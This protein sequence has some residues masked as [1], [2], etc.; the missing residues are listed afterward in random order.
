M[1]VDPHLF[2]HRHA[3]KIS[4]GS[5]RIRCNRLWLKL[6]QVIRSENIFRS[7]E[8][9]NKPEWRRRPD[10][11]PLKA[12]GTRLAMVLAPLVS[13]S[14]VCKLQICCWAVIVRAANCIDMQLCWGLKIGSLPQAMADVDAPVPS[15][16]NEEFVTKAWIERAA[17]IC[18]G[19]TNGS[20]AA[21]TSWVSESAMWVAES[22]WEQSRVINRRRPLEG[23]FV[24]LSSHKNPC[25]FHVNK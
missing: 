19:T 7:L 12:I 24:E 4:Q 1:R 13:W 15:S 10:M 20:W 18:V 8:K 22:S 5:S 23:Q 16:C 11:K 25:T 17:A 3:T 14:M 21:F 2:G 6:N 9:K